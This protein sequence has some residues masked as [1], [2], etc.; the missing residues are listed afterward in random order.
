MFF[1]EHFRVGTIAD[2]LGIHHDTVSRAIE[3]ERFISNGRLYKSKLDPYREFIAT[4]LSSYPRLRSTR[5]YEMLVSRGYAGSSSQVRATVAK[6]RPRQTEVFVR[7]NTMPGEQAQVDWG[8]F[9]SIVIG[10]AKRKLSAFVMVLSWSRAIHALFTLDQTTESFLRGHAE[11]FDYFG[12]CARILLYDNLKS[13]VL[14]RYGQSIHFNPR[15]LELASHYH[16]MPRPVGVARGNEKG[17]VE[18]QIRFLRDRF[19]AARHFRD[20][21][22]LNAQFVE[23]RDTW[24]HARPCPGDDSITVAQA[25]ERERNVLLP[26]PQNPFFCDKV[27]AVSSGK[28][29][30]IRFDL[31]DYSIPHRLVMKPLTLCASATDVKILDGQTVSASHNRSYDRGQRIENPAHITELLAWKRNA[32]EPKRRDHICA[33]VK[34]AEGFFLEVLNSGGDLNTATKRLIHLLDDYGPDAMS[35]A[36]GEALERGTPTVASVTH[37][38]ER[39]RRKQ[40]MAPPVRIE[41]PDHPGVKD[42]RT[43]QHNLETYDDLAKNINDQS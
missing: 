2:V 20:V 25:L 4:T 3:T 13:A 26:L 24:A 5:I 14:Q 8:S 17:K 15:I 43:A 33:F 37:I 18:R 38:L 11:A 41:L 23:W 16:F 19:F 32:R 22:D 34:N 6:M 9:G 28:T 29:P 42:L 21:D 12:G 1:A 7:L 10:R 39:N 36:I 31:N 30:Y 35:A 27:A 40:K